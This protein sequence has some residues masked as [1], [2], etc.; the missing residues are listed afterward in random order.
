L[1]CRIAVIAPAANAGG[2]DVAKIKSDVWL[3]M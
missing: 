2:S 1:R 3:P